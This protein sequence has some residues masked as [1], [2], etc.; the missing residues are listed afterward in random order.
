MWASSTWAPDVPIDGWLDVI[1][2]TR[3]RSAVVGVVTRDDRASAAALIAALAASRLAIL[4][5]GGAAAGDGLGEDLEPGRHVALPMP[6]VE[7]AEVM[8]QAVGR[9]R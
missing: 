1:A 8:A 6:V 5:T 7:A 2:R 9:R 4:A 3:A